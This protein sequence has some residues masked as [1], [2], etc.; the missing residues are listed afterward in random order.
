MATLRPAHLLS[1]E[2]TPKFGSTVTIKE[3]SHELIIE[4]APFFVGASG[5]GANSFEGISKNL[6]S[7]NYEIVR[8]SGI[9]TSIIY[10]LTSGTITKT[11]FYLPNGSVDK[12]VL[13]GS[14]LPA[15]L[16]PTKQ[17]IYTSGVLSGFEYI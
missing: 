3:P 6:K 10:T 14:N 9:V 1:L 5:D 7:N 8:T 16:K 11:I 13:S 17:F 2:I 12:I 15:G 4:L